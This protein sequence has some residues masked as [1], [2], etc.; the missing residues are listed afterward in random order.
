MV[1]ADGIDK[2]GGLC[3][4]FYVQSF[5]R[6]LISLYLPHFADDVLAFK[7]DVDATCKYISKMRGKK[8]A[9]AVILATFTALLEEEFPD[10]FAADMEVEEPAEVPTSSKKRGRQSV[11]SA[12]SVES[13]ERQP[14]KKAA[15]Q[16]VE[17]AP[18]TEEA[19]GLS[20]SEK[21]SFLF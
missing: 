14:K 17:E 18:E 7:E 10:V 3:A 2:Y 8:P 15:R 5:T 9:A 20:A 11:E 19:A 21:V 12:A 1:D 4:L 13:P 6:L 16:V